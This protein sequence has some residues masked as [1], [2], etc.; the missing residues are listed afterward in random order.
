MQVGVMGDYT[1]ANA[2]LGAKVCA[3]C[4][5]GLAAF[6]RQLMEARK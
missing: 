5:A 2:E 1:G 4:V 3:E 6:I